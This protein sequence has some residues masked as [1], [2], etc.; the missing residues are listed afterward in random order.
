MTRQ[1]LVPGRWM[2]KQDM[3]VLVDLCAAIREYEERG[4]FDQLCDEVFVDNGSLTEDENAW[5]IEWFE[6]DCTMTPPTLDALRKCPHIYAMATVLW[7]RAK[8]GE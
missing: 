3:A 6:G 5:L 7:E 8:Y 2:R 1:R 4:F